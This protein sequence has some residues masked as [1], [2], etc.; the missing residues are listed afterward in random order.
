MLS[1]GCFRAPQLPQK[2]LSVAQ[3]S[4]ISAVAPRHRSLT[5]VYYSTPKN[6][7]TPEKSS[8]NSN[9]ALDFVVLACF[10]KGTLICGSNGYFSV[11]PLLHPPPWFTARCVEDTWVAGIMWS[12]SSSS[13][14]SAATSTSPDAPAAEEQQTEGS[15]L[16]TLISVLR[17]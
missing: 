2:P 15:K 3:G 14:A 5:P 7:Q 11:S 13:T 8:D 16:K 17:K 4:L 1:A 10:G 12:F 9:F 6:T